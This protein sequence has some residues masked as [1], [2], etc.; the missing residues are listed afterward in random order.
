M[1]FLLPLGAIALAATV[2]GPADAASTINVSLWDKGA[3]A[4]MATDL[5]MNMGGHD[6]SKATMGVRAVPAAVKAGDVTFEV[7]NNSSETIHEMIVVPVRDPKDPLP[8]IDAENRVDE[9]AAGHL[10]EVSEL[11][12]G[13]TG[14][15]RLHLAP[16]K[17]LLF[18]NVPGHFA[19]G[20]WT[21]VTVQ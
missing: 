11:D 16:G 5:G 8:Y 2:S 14:A 9:D 4:D 10:G 18:C 17:Y 6:M 7:T 19:N 21:E 12:P 13:K 15:L 3:R 20:M 1:A